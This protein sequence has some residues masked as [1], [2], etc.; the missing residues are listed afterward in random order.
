MSD[1]NQTNPD[2]DISRQQ[3]GATY[4]SALLGAA[5]KS[6]NAQQV[7]D[8]L[9]ELVDEVVS[10]TPSLREVLATPRL[11]AEEKCGVLKRT[12]EERMSEELLTFLLVVGQHGRL[13]CLQ[14]IANAARRQHNEKVGRID[15]FVTTADEIDDELGN[16][17]SDSLKNALHQDVDLH[18]S[19]DPEIIGGLVIRVGDKIY[20]GS[21]ANKLARVRTETIQKTVQQLRESVSRFTP[22]S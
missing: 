19:V 6:G 2:K 21:V 22:A 8:E 7:V 17:I 11:S 12:F 15:V 20:D 16:R 3:L 1:E 5:E 10:K 18:R 14:Q 9:T 4:A 13:D